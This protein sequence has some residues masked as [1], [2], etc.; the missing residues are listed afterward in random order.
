MNSPITSGQLKKLMTLFGHA[1]RAGTVPIPD[2][3]GESRPIDVRAQRIGFLTGVVKRSISSSKDLTQAEAETAI[4][5]LTKMVPAHL[6]TRK[7]KPPMPR[8]RAQ[9]LGTAGRKGFNAGTSL[10]GAEEW[11]R[12]SALL[13][14]LNWTMKTLEEHLQSNRSPIGK[15][16]KILTMAH[17]N[18]VRW[19]L[20]NIL[21]SRKRKEGAA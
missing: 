11:K 12:I 3:P 7:R 18:R 2:S 9:E 8:D 10:A 21:R 1:F 5:A 15:G 4:R 14:E 19:A 17:A 6:N 13:A 20:K 16:G